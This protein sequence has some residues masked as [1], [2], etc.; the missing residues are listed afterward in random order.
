MAS[1][2]VCV[3]A[4]Q[5]RPARSGKE[6]GRNSTGKTAQQLLCQADGPLAVCKTAVI[7]ALPQGAQK[8]TSHKSTSKICVFPNFIA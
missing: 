5:L 2:V 4:A 6:Q 8:G 1:L 7:S 3:V